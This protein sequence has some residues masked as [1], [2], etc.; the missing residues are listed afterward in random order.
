MADALLLNEFNSYCLNMGFDFYKCKAKD[1]PSGFN[2]VLFGAVLL[3]CSRITL[4]P[5]FRISAETCPDNILL[6]SK[7]K[8]V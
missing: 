2:R 7:I 5:G 1:M 6:S 8:F 4:V 3:C